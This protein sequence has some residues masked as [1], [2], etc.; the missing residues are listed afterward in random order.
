MEDFFAVLVTVTV[1]D[2]RRS[3][4]GMWAVDSRLDVCTKPLQIAKTARKCR[5][6]VTCAV[7]ER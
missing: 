4:A 5:T 7:P 1:I 2:R 3:L 6:D